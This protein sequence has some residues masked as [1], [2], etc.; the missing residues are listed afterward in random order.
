MLK[1]FFSLV[2]VILICCS[3]S[4]NVFAQTEHLHVEENNVSNG[5]EEPAVTDTSTLCSG[6]VIEDSEIVGNSD[7]LF[8][9]YADSEYLEWLLG[10]P[11][12]IKC[13]STSELLE[14][15]L[16]SP[17]MGQ[18]IYSSSTF[19]EREIDFSC[20]EAFRELV[21]REDCIEVLEN[22]VG[23]ILY[24]SENDELDIAKFE[25]LLA[26]PSVG[27]ILFESPSAAE[28]CPNLQSIYTQS[29][30]VIST[31]GNFVG[32]I[33]GINYCSAGTI[34]TANNRSVEVCTPHREWTS[35]EISEINSSYDYD[36]NIR[37]YNA[38]TVYN[39]HSYAWY[40]HSATNSYWI[41]DITQFTLD[42]A[43]S[44]V[45]S[46]QINDII[47]Y[48]DANGN[49]IHSG[50]VY[51]IGS[52]G[53]LTIGS[54]WGQAGAYIHSIG[55]VPADYYSNPYIGQISYRLYRY[56]D[57]ANQPT[58]NNYHSG[59]RH[60]YEYADICIVCGK[61]INKTWVS[62]VCS[63]PP[64]AVIMKIKGEENI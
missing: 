23:T 31:D 16:Q 49:P 64:C 51:S 62:V 54:K 9:T 4:L 63:G 33:N 50:V 55:S 22:Y 25:K 1:K 11:D 43:C 14:Y 53:E 21:S 28:S 18:Q 48:M 32:E 2:L 3:T 58:G 34:S 27:S 37:L 38:S 24:S 46:A 20:H 39:C 60:Y 40:R 30:V 29:E 12:E 13:A 47:V 57:Y 44:V 59:S 5:N 7:Y 15:F 56:H 52:S 36:G 41:M 42:S 10:V 6:S 61:Q 8:V 19:E 45:T 35:A 17:F 26:Q